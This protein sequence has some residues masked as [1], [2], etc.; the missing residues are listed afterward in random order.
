MDRADFETTL[1]PGT[2]FLQ[3]AAQSA[4]VAARAA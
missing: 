1:V 4:K 2:G 3:K